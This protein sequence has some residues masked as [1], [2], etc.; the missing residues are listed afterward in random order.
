MRV[1]VM[2][3]SMCEAFRRSAPGAARTALTAGHGGT[4][5]DFPKSKGCPQVEQEKHGRCSGEKWEG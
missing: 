1:D 4:S 3:G 2:A 5:T